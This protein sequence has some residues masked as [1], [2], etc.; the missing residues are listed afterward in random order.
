[1]VVWQRS[2]VDLQPHATFHTEEWS[3]SLP[4]GLFPTQNPEFRHQNQYLD[5]QSLLILLQWSTDGTHSTA[6]SLDRWPADAEY[7]EM[8]EGKQ[9][10][11]EMKGT[12]ISLQ[13][14]SDN[15]LNRS[16]CRDV[17]FNGALTLQHVSVW[18]RFSAVF[19]CP[20]HS[21]LNLW[22]AVVCSV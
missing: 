12:Q 19:T 22:I 7:N 6:S 10:A 13:W 8:K 2:G 9:R 15:K 1:M 3:K 4:H 5:S 14:W 16:C 20:S 11:K 17:L 21:S 18:D